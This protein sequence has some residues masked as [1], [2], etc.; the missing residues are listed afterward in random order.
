MIGIFIFSNNISMEYLKPTVPQFE[1]SDTDTAFVKRKQERTVLI[2]QKRIEMLKL[3]KNDETFKQHVKDI[4]YYRNLVQG[5][6]ET[7]RHYVK[8]LANEIEITEDYLK[9][10]NGDNYVRDLDCVVKPC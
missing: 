10:K 7:L 8:Y 5:A 1:S 4:Q 3:H 9:S 2:A 6:R